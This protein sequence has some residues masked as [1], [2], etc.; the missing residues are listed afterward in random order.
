MPTLEAVRATIT[1]AWIARENV[2]LLSARS[3]AL[4]TR[5]R[6]GEDL[7]AV[8]AST[9]ATVIRQTGIRQD[10]ASA[11]RLGQGV[12][13]GLFNGE[14]GKPFSQPQSES[15]I[16]IGRVD[17]ITPP[18][19]ALAA[20]EAQQ[21]RARLGAAA[22]DPLF[23]AAVAAA[24]ERTKATYNEDLARQALGVSATPAPATST[25]PAGR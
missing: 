9:G 6:A 14:R 3:D 21:W 15:S 13:G 24:A 20:D 10:E 2:R 5:L 11:T 8:A 7:A 4:M 25:P 12:M 19:P 16:A 1:P 17:R 23:A 18:T 22:G